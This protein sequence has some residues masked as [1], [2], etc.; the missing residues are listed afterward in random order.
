MA[1]HS[2]NLARE[3]TDRIDAGEFT[4]DKTISKA[5]I[6]RLLVISST[7]TASPACSTPLLPNPSPHPRKQHPLPALL[8]AQSYAKGR[9]GDIVQA[10]IIQG[11]HARAFLETYRRRQ[12]AQRQKIGVREGF[13]NVP[14]L[15]GTEPV[16]S[17][18]SASKA[19]AAAFS[20]PPAPMPAR[21]SSAWMEARLARST[22]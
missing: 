8:D 2:F 10:K 6:P 15:V 12:A 20:S 21:S 18:S 7:P 19:P 13:V 22:R 11:L 9:L 4:W 17:S 3:V 16:R 1:I 5:C 14:A